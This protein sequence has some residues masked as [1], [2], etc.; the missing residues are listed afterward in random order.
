M[1]GLEDAAGPWF[2]EVQVGCGLRPPTAELAATFFGFSWGSK[3]GTA[4]P[5][6]VTLLFPCRLLSGRGTKLKSSVVSFESLATIRLRLNAAKMEWWR[7]SQEEK[8][9]DASFTDDREARDPRKRLEEGFR[10]AAA[11]QVMAE[12]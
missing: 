6:N 3:R 4:R 12:W 9:G 1:V 5:I 11:E 2:A 7:C 10:D 8:W